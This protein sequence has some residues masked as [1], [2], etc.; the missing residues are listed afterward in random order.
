MTNQKIFHVWLPGRAAVVAHLEWTRVNLSLLF[1]FTRFYLMLSLI[2]IVLTQP[3]YGI[4]LDRCRTG[5]RS[6]HRCCWTKSR[7][8]RKF[9]L[10]SKTFESR[11]LSLA[12]GRRWWPLRRP[13]F[14]TRAKPSAWPILWTV[15]S[16]N[17]KTMW[18]RWV[19][20]MIKGIVTLWLTISSRSV[21]TTYCLVLTGTF[22]SGARFHT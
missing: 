8:S 11:A 14:R 12:T 21:A 6:T 7:T 13:P 20:G 3:F 17:S 15:P 22:L 5:L 16:W 4:F 19:G 9:S 2:L 18:R 1:Y 10:S